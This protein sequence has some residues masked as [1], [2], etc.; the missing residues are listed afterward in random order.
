MLEYMPEQREWRRLPRQWLINLLF[1]FVGE[2]FERWVKEKVAER[3]SA[4][5][6]KNKLD[7]AIAPEIAGFFAKSDRVSRKEILFKV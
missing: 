4:F 2:L 6:S 5:V 7:I 1:T 3:N